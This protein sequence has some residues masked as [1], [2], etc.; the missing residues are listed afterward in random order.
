MT[1]GE[2]KKR[3]KKL[4][5]EIQRHDYLY[6]VLDKPEISDAAY[7]ALKRELIALEK[8]YPEFITPDSPTQRVG[9]SPL[10][11]FEKVKHRVP[12]L[13]LQDAFNEQEISDWEERIKKL[14]P[15]EKF[16]YFVELKMDGLAVS[17][18]YKNG[19]FYKGS[20]RGDGI[21]GEDVTQNIKTIKTVPLRLR[22]EEFSKKLPSE[23]EIRGE[24]FMTKKAFEELNQEQKRKGESLFANPRNAAAGSVRQLD[25]KITAS[26][27][28]DF[29]AYQIIA[30]LG[31]KTH[32]ES[33]QI[34]KQIGFKENPNNQYC[35]NLE[36]VIDFHQKIS[37][38][39]DSLP[40][41]IDGIVVT[42]NNNLLFDKLGVVGRTP[43]GS[44]AYKFPGKEATTKIKEIIVQ[45]GRTGK[46]TPVAVLEPIQ[47]GGVTISRAT[48]HN[49]DEIKRLGVKIGDTVIV[50]R[51]GD[52]IPDIVSVLKNLRTGKEKEFRM[53]KKCPICGALVYKK[54][55]EVDY[56]C[57]NKNCFATQRRRI[58][59][60]VSK[61]A[62]DIVH[63]GP[64]IVDQLI[65]EGLIKDAADI[66]ILTQGDIEPLERFAEKS[67]QNLIEAIQK[68][69]II[70]LNRLIYALGIRHIGEE[71]AQLLAKEIIKKLK[72]K[73]KKLRISQFL[74]IIQSFSLDDLTKIPDVGPI[75]G[76]SIYDWFHHK[77][78][79]EFLKK[80]EKNGIEIE[81]TQIS[82]KKQK[83]A[84]LKFVLTGEL[85]SMT[86]DQAK[87]KI[88][89][90]GGDIS[91]SVSKK[92]NFVVVG[93]NPGSKF[94]KA[95]QLGVK[96]VN[97]EE[98][99]KMI[100]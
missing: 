29:Y 91:E 41:E 63:L 96:I 45:V 27:K 93:K 67:A 43:R 42:V 19:I 22:L 6:Y 95:K 84:D 21:I 18:I 74:R 61:K 72:I 25:P 39:R 40:Y 30:D 78:N 24:V 83:L 14:F 4:R 81:L 11:K 97:E 34:L 31:Q 46:L 1:K 94:Q 69:K 36:E 92:T 56:Y 62:F 37:K 57:S 49:E 50:Q 85:E 8:Q 60:F 76:Q 59:H 16:D 80:L 58:Y 2:A 10:E 77:N 38:I 7:D 98:F 70:P 75:V 53:P 52:V 48:L 15:D 64:K 13:S 55:S 32:Q 9:G 12:M 23:I 87:E 73:I 51:A 65:E 99:L 68:S 33:H 44:I 47:V 82:I 26:R 71:N 35:K 100:H 20:T 3:I 88:R 17:L 90:L 79:I 54:E 66:F 5:K 89:E 86:R 28:L